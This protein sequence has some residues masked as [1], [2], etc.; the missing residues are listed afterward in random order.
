M[1]YF[2][3]PRNVGKNN[4]MYID[5]RSLKEVFCVDCGKKI[6]VRAI[7]CSHCSKVGINNNNYGNKKISKK[8][9]C[10]DCGK[11]IRDYKAKRC[12]SCAAKYFLNQDDFKLKLKNRMSGSGNPMFGKKQKEESRKKMS[13]KAGGTGIPGELSEYGSE[14]DSALKEQVR[15]R[16]KYICQLCGCSQIEN[17]SQLDCHHIDYNKKNNVLNNLVALCKSCHRKTNWNRNYW[18]EIFKKCTSVPHVM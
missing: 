2:R 16:D 9:Y 10:I 7:R 3:E 4:P 15:F 11:E 18:K 8:Y 6:S 12:K 14:F 17:G 5:G 13:L 1:G